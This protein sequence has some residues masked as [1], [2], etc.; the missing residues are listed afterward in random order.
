MR[1]RCRKTHS[2]PPETAD[3]NPS[4]SIVSRALEKL[5]DR[6]VGAIE[7]ISE[8]RREEGRVPWLAAGPE[9]PHRDEAR[10]DCGKGCSDGKQE[11]AVALPQLAESGG[12][13]EDVH[14]VGGA[15]RNICD[16]CQQKQTQAE[17][18]REYWP[19]KCIANRQIDRHDCRQHQVIG[20][21]TRLPEVDL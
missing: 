7:T 14:Y 4:S 15:V 21:S 2:M 19:R 1:R 9:H 16:D 12:L 5:N 13:G 8:F 11:P 17:I 10:D 20:N 3:A 6:I 18:N